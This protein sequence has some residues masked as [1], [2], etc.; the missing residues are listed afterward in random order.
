[1]NRPDLDEFTALWRIA[2]DPE[3]QARLDA[4]ARSARRRGLFLA[5]IDYAV[6]FLLIGVSV[7]G[8]FISHTPLTLAASVVIVI[9]TIWMTWRR[10]ALRQMALTLHTSTREG[11][12]E[13]SLRNARAN[14]RRVTLSLTTIPFL[15]PLA[16]TFKVSIRT[17]GGPEEVLQAF[18]EWTQTTRALITV[19]VLLIIAGLSLRSRR[20]LQEEIRRLESLRR[21]YELEADQDSKEGLRL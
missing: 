8:A 20:R 1:M 16:L 12:I 10:R 15:V 2:P 21:G 18:V 7:I 4:Y 17:G 5:Y 19:V 3:E 6:A 13:S 14:Q 9:V 11:F